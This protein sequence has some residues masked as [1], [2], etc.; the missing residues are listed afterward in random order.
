MWLYWYIWSLCWYKLTWRS[1]TWNCYEF[2]EIKQYFIS[3]Y[4]WNVCVCVY[5]CK[6]LCWGR[7]TIKSDAYWQSNLSSLL[8]LLLSFFTSSCYLDKPRST[9]VF[10]IY[11]GQSL[12]IW[13]L[14]NIMPEPIKRA[15]RKEW[16]L[17]SS[18]ISCL[19]LVQFL[20][21]LW[22]MINSAILIFFHC[23]LAWWLL[24][25]P[26]I[27]WLHIMQGRGWPLVC[28]FLQSRMYTT[29]SVSESSD[30]LA[31][32]FLGRLLAPSVNSLLP[33]DSSLSLV[34][35][36]PVSKAGR[37]LCTWCEIPSTRTDCCLHQSL[38][39]A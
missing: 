17:S 34:A 28:V 23:G 19:F 22:Q 30:E 32:T 7:S 11:W 26:L 6:I 37:R 16:M 25:F 9:K 39:H 1:S 14:S 13:A 36:W 24:H 10:S 20:V 18:P 4:S 31:V 3:F 29:V 12:P 8:P 5:W 35:E 21:S 38:A 15:G 27:S 33:D 2:Y